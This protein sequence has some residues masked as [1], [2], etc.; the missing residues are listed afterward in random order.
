MSAQSE[1]SPAQSETSPAQSETSPAQSETSPAQPKTSHAQPKTSPAQ[2]KT[3]SAVAQIHV[4][5]CNGR[6]YKTTSGLNAHKKSQ[7]HINWER[8]NELRTL[9]TDLTRRDNHILHLEHDIKI[10]RDFNQQ[11]LRQ[12]YARRERDERTAAL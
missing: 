7:T 8:N 10:L 3:S 2:P 9:R 5:E 11:L 12:L 4:C 6:D 1:T